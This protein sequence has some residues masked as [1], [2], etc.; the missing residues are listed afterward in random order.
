[1]ADRS[2]SV[3]PVTSFTVKPSRAR[4]P[5]A[6]PMAAVPLSGPDIAPRIP[7]SRWVPS[8][9]SMRLVHCVMDGLALETLIRPPMAFR[10]K[11]AL[12]APRT[13]SICSTSISSMFAELAFSCGTPSM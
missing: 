2:S 6:R 9:E 7:R 5:K 1:M 10:P 4:V 3:F 8:G 12:C 11:S 13:N